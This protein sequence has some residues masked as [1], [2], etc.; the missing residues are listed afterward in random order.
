MSSIPVALALAI[1]MQAAP[2]VSP[3][4]MV[5]FAQK[6]SRLDPLAIHDNSTGRSYAPS[7]EREAVELASRLIRAQHSVDLGIMQINN[8]N[9]A[10]LRVSIPESFDPRISMRTG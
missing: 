6:E 8:A 10:R 7:N 2:S 5:T 1:A 4:T 3:D 9:L